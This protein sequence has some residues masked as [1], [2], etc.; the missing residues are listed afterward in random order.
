MLSLVN[1]DLQRFAPVLFDLLRFVLQECG[2]QTS[3]EALLDAVFDA[4]KL[5]VQI[6]EVKQGVEDASAFKSLPQWMQVAVSDTL[7][8]AQQNMPR[9]VGVEQKRLTKWKKLQHIDPLLSCGR[10]TNQTRQS[11]W[12][13]LVKA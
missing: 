9:M 3:P 7:N 1:K 12:L 10:P 8:M 6:T 13:R 5:K 11:R 2:I 4:A